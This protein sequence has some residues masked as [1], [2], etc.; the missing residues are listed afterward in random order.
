ML[1]SELCD[2]SDAYIVVKETIDLLATAANEN[3]KTEE[4]VVFK[5]N[6]PFRSCF[7]KINSTLI[8]NAEDLDIVVLMYNILEY[9]QN[10]SMTS[11]RLWNY[12]RDYI[13]N[14]NDNASDGKSFKYKTKTAWK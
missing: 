11:G 7:S 8:D 13:D 3:D 4:N 10:Y 14:T 9:S 12:Y 2:Y 5:N 1:R 6:A